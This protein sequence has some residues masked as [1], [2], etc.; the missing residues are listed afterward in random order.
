MYGQQKTVKRDNDGDR[1]LY[2]HRNSAIRIGG[3]GLGFVGAAEK[4]IC[5]LD[6]GGTALLTAAHPEFPAVL[7]PCSGDGLPL[8]IRHRVGAAATERDDVI[9]AV[10]WTSPAGFADRRAGMLPLE[11]RVTSRDRCSLAG[12][13]KGWRSSQAEKS[14]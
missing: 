11:F 14:L 9:L 2:D 13:E 12:S 7:G 1:A 3:I 4:S 10:A 5:W 6:L 8:H